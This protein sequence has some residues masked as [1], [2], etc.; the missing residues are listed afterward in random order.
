MST[1]VKRLFRSRDERMIAGVAGGL[2]DYFGVDPTIVRLLFVFAVFFGVG[3]SLGFVLGLQ[4]SQF[5]QECSAVHHCIECVVV[6][7]HHGHHHSCHFTALNVEIKCVRFVR[8]C[9]LNLMNKFC[10]PGVGSE[11][12]LGEEVRC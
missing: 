8:S 4:L 5:A 12:W 9:S 7:S 3:G 2:G 11:V 6:V 1:E 10:L